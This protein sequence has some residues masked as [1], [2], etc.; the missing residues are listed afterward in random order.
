MTFCNQ[1]NRVREWNTGNDDIF[2]Y[3]SRTRNGCR[4]AGDKFSNFSYGTCPFAVSFM[5]PPSIYVGTDAQG[6]SQST[7]KS[8]A[9][10]TGLTKYGCEEAA[11]GSRYHAVGK[12]MYVT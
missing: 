9:H 1:I 11:P 4:S 3:I 5:T 6:D 8:S 10:A 7:R 12:H 2:N